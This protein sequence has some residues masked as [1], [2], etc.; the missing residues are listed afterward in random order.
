MIPGKVFFKE[1]G[2]TSVITFLLTFGSICID[3]EHPLIANHIG[4][5]LLFIAVLLLRKDKT[6]V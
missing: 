5:F 3:N 2:K 1:V 4:F 6:S